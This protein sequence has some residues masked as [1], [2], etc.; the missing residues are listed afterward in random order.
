MR[1]SSTGTGSVRLPAS[2]SLHQ[3]TLPRDQR[4]EQPPPGAAGAQQASAADQQ[5]QQPQE[6]SP[7]APAAAEPLPPA[8]YVKR[9]AGLTLVPAKVRARGVRGTHA[10]AAVHTNPLASSATA[11]PAPTHLQIMAM[12]ELV[13]LDLGG[14]KITVV[15]PGFLPCLPVLQALLLDGNAIRALPGDIAALT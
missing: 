3:A 5:Q 13:S 10:S 7:A 4:S 6:A 8:E 2:A 14:N 12:P 9:D 11:R 15:P 1:G